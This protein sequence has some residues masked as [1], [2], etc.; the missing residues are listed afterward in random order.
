MTDHAELL[1]TGAAGRIG[2][3]IRPQL[4]ARF[5]NV[6]LLDAHPVAD[7]RPGEEGVVAD[8]RDLDAMQKAMAG[9]RCVIH[10]AGIPQDDTWPKL[11]D[12]NIDGLYTVF[13]A[14]RRAGVRRVV[15]ASS[16]H[17]VAFTP[18]G[19]RVPID[20][21]P[22][23]SGLYGVTKIFGEAIGKL[24]ATKHGIEVV[25][26]R[27]AAFQPTPQDYRQLHVWISPR[28]MAQLAIRAV[29]AQGISFLTV[30]GVSA[31]TRNPYDRAGWD[32]LN[33]VPQDDAE[34]FLKTA[35]GL[36]SPARESDRYYGGDACLRGPI[37]S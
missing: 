18:V 12:A 29:E 19:E 6:R 24:Y 13:E 22:R 34:T 23:P 32:I 20:T 25:C 36:A 14:A 37:E 8:I 15:F 31:N 26:L 7:L 21:E 35:P 27:I 4:L 33:Y 5:G 30:F 10:L 28:D 17:A 3:A 2:S 9:I 16:H 1:V 11:R